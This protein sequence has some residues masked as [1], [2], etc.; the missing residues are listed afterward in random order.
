MSKVIVLIFCLC[1]LSTGTSF[2]Q[3]KP[4]YDSKYKKFNVGYKLEIP[5]NQQIQISFYNKDSSFNTVLLD[6]TFKKKQ[7]VI[8]LFSE[9]IDSEKNNYFKYF[10]ITIPKV[11]SGIYYM[12]MIIREKFLLTK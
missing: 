1:I 3:F 8:M 7:K 10:I 6:T 9:N 2:A 12:Q 11:N 5:A 4:L